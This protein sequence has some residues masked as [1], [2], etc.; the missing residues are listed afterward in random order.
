MSRDF[1]SYLDSVLERASLLHVSL[2]QDGEMIRQGR[3]YVAPPD[4]H[5]T[6]S[7]GVMRVLKG[8]REN[9]HRPAIDPLFRTAAR[10]YRER[11]IGVLLSGLLDDGAAGL[12]V[13]RSLGGLSIVQDPKDATAPQMPEAALLNSGAD[14][15][16]PAAEI[17]PKIVEIVESCSG[18]AMNEKEPEQSLP[19]PDDPNLRVANPSEGVGSPSVFA[20]PECHGVLWEIKDGTLVRFQC[21]VGHAYSINSLHDEQAGAIETALWAAMRALEEKSAL[22]RRLSETMTD[23]KMCER[24]KEQAET[25]RNHADTI[26]RILFD[27][28]E[29]RN[30]KVQEAA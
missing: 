16:L 26:R 21:R 23:K 29:T 3:I 22:D 18:G 1:T 25:D 13:I 12:R 30:E 14:F 19:A 5:L 9:R 10:V 28:D 11:V 20:C 15:I 27:G 17:G 24:F 2:P 4:Y 6:L 8:A 7:P